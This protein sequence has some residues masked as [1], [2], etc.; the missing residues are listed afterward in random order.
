MKRIF[1][2]GLLAIMAFMTLRSETT[3]QAACAAPQD[4]GSAIHFRIT[5][6]Y[7]D[8]S[9]DQV[10]TI[11]AYNWS[12]TV[13]LDPPPTGTITIDDINITAWT[14][15]V[16]DPIMLVNGQATYTIP[17]DS[18]GDHQVSPSGSRRTLT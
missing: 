7:G 12:N 15:V 6:K 10:V 3:A 9:G 8:S 5:P 11:T 4:C 13:R 2:I 1:M 14:W 18:M 17:G 16:S